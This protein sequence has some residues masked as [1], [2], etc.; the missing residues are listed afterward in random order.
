MSERGTIYR[1]RGNARGIAAIVSLWLNPH[2]ITEQRCLAQHGNCIRTRD[3]PEIMQRRLAE[4][5]L[6]GGKA[7]RWLFNRMSQLAGAVTMAV[8]EEHGPDEML[9]RL[10]DPWWFQAFG[11]VLGFDWHS[12]G[13]TTV[14]CGALRRLARLTTG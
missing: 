13:L 7:P 10:A 14:T 12:S 8:V 3:G 2:H 1:I 5:P 11:S 9:R 4:P 6:H